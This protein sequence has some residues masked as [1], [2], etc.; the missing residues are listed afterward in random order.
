MPIKLKS[1][2]SLA[3]VYWYMAATTGGCDL[4]YFRR[5]AI[6]LV[7]SNT[8]KKHLVTT[9]IK[10][11]LIRIQ[12]FNYNHATTHKL[13]DWLIK[14]IIAQRP[15]NSI[16]AIFRT[17]TSSIIYKKEGW[18]QSFVAAVIRLLFRNQQRMSIAYRE[19]GTLQKHCQLYF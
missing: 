3:S 8:K 2:L 14:L 15:A 13:I 9:K 12:I 19:H 17:R 1:H 18:V 6:R 4:Y 7:S 11:Y 10:V 5:S 16:S